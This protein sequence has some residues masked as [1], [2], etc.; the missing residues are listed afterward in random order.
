MNYEAR[1]TI[2]EK[3]SNIKYAEVTMS[4]GSRRSA[5]I[6]E[7][8]AVLCS[9]DKTRS[10]LID[11][12][13][14]DDGESI[15]I[16]SENLYIRQD[17]EMKENS[18]LDSLV[19]MGIV[20]KGRPVLIDG[21]EYEKYGFY[22]RLRD[23][24]SYDED[25]SVCE[26]D[27]DKFNENDC[28]KFAECI[29]AGN[30]FK[31]KKLFNNIIRIVPENDEGTEPLLFAKETRHKNHIFGMSD[32][33]NSQILK[34]TPKNCK[35]NNA[36]PKQGEC[37]GIVRKGLSKTEAKNPYHIG[38]VLYDLNGVNIT[39]EGFTGMFDKYRPRFCFYDKNPR[40]RSF[41]T[42]WT[43]ALKDPETAKDMGF[44]EN[45]ETIVLKKRG[46]IDSVMKYHYL[47][48]YSFAAMEI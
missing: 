41:H 17:F 14:Y 46:D 27:D 36:L 20:V 11:A 24:R 37:Y 29:T 13:E 15:H 6:S 35:D 45:S 18:V 2:A 22:R 33:N 31:S 34:N 16:S 38:F 43:G 7:K 26:E 40:G 32:Y 25:G 42:V 47:D 12:M 3:V 44:F 4:E 23:F 48:E 5:T 19:S 8:K 10:M 21:V 28:L 39:L 30:S 1:K 9:L